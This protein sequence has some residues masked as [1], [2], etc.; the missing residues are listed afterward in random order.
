MVAPGGH[1]MLHTPVNGYWAHGFH[2]FNPECLR[3][4]FELNGFRIIYEKFSTADG[5]P[6]PDPSKGDILTWMVARKER[7]FDKFVCP[8]QGKWYTRYV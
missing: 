6:V 2:I 3:G 1:Y 8:Q 5:I 7:E 4:A